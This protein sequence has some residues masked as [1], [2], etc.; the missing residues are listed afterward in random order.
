MTVTVV[1]VGIAAG[2]VYVVGASFVVGVG[3]KDPQAELL[4]VT[5][6]FAWGLALTSL[7]IRTRK[8]AAALTWRDA[9][10]VPKNETAMGMGATMVTVAEIVLVESATAVAVMVTVAPE[11]MAV[12][13]V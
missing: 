7:V 10:T 12:G 5:V 9:G 8:G 4:Q 1:P 3:L 13:A 2:A 6:H 11:G